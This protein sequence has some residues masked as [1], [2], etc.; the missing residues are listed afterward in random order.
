MA[1]RLP[2]L[3]P[4][5]PANLQKKSGNKT[6]V[7]RATGRK[8]HTHD[9]IIKP[10]PKRNAEKNWLHIQ[11]QND[12]QL[13]KLLE[14]Y[15]I[16][17]LTIED[18]FSHSNRIK[19]EKF[20]NYIYVSF[21]GFHLEK[22]QIFSRNFNFI[23]THKT[24]ISVAHEPRYTILNLLNDAVKTKELMQ[25][26]PDFI[27]HRIL[28]VETDHTLEIV[29]RIDELFEEYENKLLT[30]HDSVNIAEVFELRSSL[31]QI[32][33][34]ILTHKE[35][36]DVLLSTDKDFFTEESEA[37]FRDV[38]DHAIKT[39]DSVD[40]IIQ[41]ISSAIEAYHTISSRRT[42]E[43]MKILTILTSIMLPMTLITGIFGMNFR[44]MP[45]LND[46]HGFSLSVMVMGVVGVAM[47]L[48]FKLKKWL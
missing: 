45:W 36:F 6:L 25:K 20:E 46:H 23:I 26:G 41:A 29:H 1:L 19:L 16:H 5:R 39:L 18:I 14:R 3:R 47:L 42:N 21:R 32:K 7:F 38:R 9:D 12:Q 48:L 40:G 37:F 8:I 27:L 24:L 35:I 4:P 22:N 15:K 17:P 30:Y 34:V 31:Q 11:A 10:L 13:N 44:L 43:V 33:K 2:Q 28:D